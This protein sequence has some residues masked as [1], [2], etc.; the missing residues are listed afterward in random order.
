MAHDHTS[1]FACFDGFNGLLKGRDCV[2][3]QKRLLSA[4]SGAGYMV[5]TLAGEESL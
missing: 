5:Q 2:Q 4:E 1:F 3:R